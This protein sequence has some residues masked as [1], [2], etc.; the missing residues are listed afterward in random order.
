M[1]RN[2]YCLVAGFP[3]ITIEDSKLQFGSAELKQTLLEELHVDD[4][5]LLEFLFLKFDNKNLLNLLLENDNEFEKNGN[6]TK[7][8]L[9]EEI[10]EPANLPDYMIKFIKSYKNKDRIYPNLLLEDEL[11]VLYYDYLTTIDNDF[12]K[13]W[14]TLELN[15]LNFMTGLN[16]RKHDLKVDDYLIGSNVV[17]E[18][19]KKSNAADFGL[20]N[21]FP[22]CE[23]LLH[24]F[25]EKNIVM[26]EIELDSF[27]LNYLEDQIFFKYFTIEAILVF[28]IKLLMTERYLSLDVEIGKTKLKNFLSKMENT[29]ELPKEFTV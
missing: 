28:M 25:N 9:E 16:C 22:H 11:N 2:Y 13:E 5:K 12:L 8:F 29:Y 24:I 10:Q 7:T 14:F 21:D 20:N 3:D 19:I 15:C 1:A 27:K 17:T 4:F 6:Y 23:R 18:A 26:R